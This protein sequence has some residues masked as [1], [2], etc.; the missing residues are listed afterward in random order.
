MKVKY[1][2]LIISILLAGAGLGWYFYQ[3]RSNDL[4]LDPF[5]SIQG[6]VKVP[7]TFIAYTDDFSKV[8]WGAYAESL[9]KHLGIEEDQSAQRAVVEA[10]FKQ[11]NV[12]PRSHYVKYF[13]KDIQKNLQ[14]GPGLPHWDVEIGTLKCT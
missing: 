11:I 6:C 7:N 8:D 12:E 1:W 3:R 9:Q 10:F 13:Q 5:G 2:L 4:S 14:S